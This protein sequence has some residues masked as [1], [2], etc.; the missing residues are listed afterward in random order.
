VSIEP[1]NSSM[2]RVPRR[3]LLLLLTVVLLAACA[4]T[5]ERGEALKGAWLVAGGLST[6]PVAA[7]SERQAT[8]PRVALAL[9]GGGLR[10]YAHIGVLQALEEA[11]IRPD[12]VVGTS[13]GAIIGAAYASGISPDQLWQLV[14]SMRVTS[15]VDVT[16]HG[17][18]FVKGAALA[19]W[20]NTLVGYQPIERFPVQFAAVATDIDRSLPYVIAQG[21]AGEA[22]L[23]SAAIPG[24]FL[25]VQSGGHVLVDGGVASLVPVRAA[26]A[27]GADVVIAV[28]IYC[29]GPRYP[30]KSAISMWLRVSQTQSCLLSEPETASADVLIAPAITSA[31]LDDAAGREAARQQGYKAAVAALPS[32]SAALRHHG[33][34]P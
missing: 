23:A 32:L 1:A 34:G 13:I 29:K 31:G 20:V 33:V 2:K 28:D 24:V 4:G 18:G 17:P 11:G 30:S 10:G 3:L 21:D 25:P 14:N 26:R 22:V 12:L 27:L 7:V 19:R 5:P 16:L 8:S 15:L 9:G 6:Q